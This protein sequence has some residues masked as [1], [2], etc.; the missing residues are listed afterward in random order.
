MRSSLGFISRSY[1]AMVAVCAVLA[2]PTQVTSALPIEPFGERYKLTC[3]EDRRAC[4]GL[5][6]GY[7][8]IGGATGIVIAKSTDGEVELEID[9]GSDEP[10]LLSAEEVS[11]LALTLSWDGDSNP[12]QL[13]ASGLPCIDL[14]KQ[15]AHAFVVP[16]VSLDYE[17]AA[18]ATA[19][20]CPSFVVETRIYNPSDPTGQKF[21]SSV[22]TRVAGTANQLTI[23]FS[24]FIQRGPRGSA[25]FSCVGAI[26]VTFRFSGFKEL[27]FSAGPFYTNGTE[28]LTP[29]PTATREPTATV[30][31]TPTLTPTSTP[32]NTPTA[33]PSATA[34]PLVTRAAKPTLV[35]GFATEVSA[36]S[37]SE[38]ARTPDSGG[39]TPQPSPR[40][41]ASPATASK[42]SAGL[43]G[44]ETV[45]GE[46]VAAY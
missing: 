35:M 42:P 46:V 6:R 24:N 28:G 4:S 10:L 29:I 31:A 1:S 26:T 18:G 7:Y 41:E 19:P 2:C 38:Y 37:G 44:E 11:E 9:R 33:L 30:T 21:S 25:D 40:T 3:D 15:G 13:S 23:P 16:R 45:Y 27:E 43:E 39:L 5:V 22:L 34:I 14:T 8:T 20:G 17:C 36:S 32:T 12:E